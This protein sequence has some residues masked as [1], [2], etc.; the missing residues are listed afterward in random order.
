[1]YAYQNNLLSIPASILYDD[2][3]L[4]S[5]STYKVWCFR[6]KLIRTRQ[7]KGKGNCA[8]VSF[9]DI[10][11]EW[12]KNAIKAKY[13]DPKEKIIEN[14][15]EN[16]IQT[17][18]LAIKFFAAHIKPNGRHL[19]AKDQ[20]TKVNSVSILNA[21]QT[22][23]NSRSNA[24]KLFG[25]QK[26]KVWQNISEA[27]NNINTKKW[28]Y[29]LPTTSRTLQRK[30]KRYLN[31]GYEA[32]IHAG[33][34]SKNAVRITKAVGDY[35]LALYSLPSGKLTI[36][37]VNE[38]YELERQ[39]HKSW[40][41]LTNS[42]I[43]EFLYKPEN[44]RIWTLARHGK[45]AY[46]RKYKH[47]ITRDKS[48]WF[49]NA[50]WAIDGTK[51]DWIHFW[52]DASNKMGAKLKINVLFDVYS[53]KIIGSAISF[54][55]SHVE[56]FKAIK[57][58]INEAECRPYF[59]TYDNQSGHKSERMQT[60]YDSLVA[61]NKGVHYAGAAYEHGNPAEGLFRRLQQQV[62]NKFWF[63]D[64]QSVTVRRDD[65]KMNTDFISTHK[66][67]L[68]TIEELYQAWEAAVALWNSKVHPNFKA[69]KFT[70]D[71]VYQHQM[72][73]QEP[74]SMFE[75]MDKMWVE[76]KK[77]PITY[78]A[79]GID[80]WIS[81]KKY[82]YEVYD[83]NG[84]IDIEFRRTS[85]GKKFIVR[86]DPEHLDTYIQLCEKDHYGN[87]V[88]VANAEPK[89]KIQEIPVLMKDGDKEQALKDLN[90]RTLELERDQKA[91]ADLVART[92]ISVESEMQDQDLLIKFKGNLTKV[93]RSK[94][95]ATET[96]SAAS[97]L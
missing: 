97:R 58:G 11:E 29:K 57:M 93:Q 85:V 78:K 13:G 79:H 5:Y 50:Y 87:I 73:M 51:L 19:S 4:M 17:D 44:E 96:L 94:V 60:L 46:K 63:N 22:V 64:G 39:N 75:I 37:E 67:E 42:A 7:G 45:E 10:A 95:E 68:K 62:I 83:A 43:Y 12:V 6:G 36:P 86:Y 28:Q 3:E 41:P 89:R 82:Q 25:K 84:D 34:G 80:L 18:P 27:V 55:E 91:Y 23:F 69:E 21:I 54:T 35:L 9:Y 32:F 24:A 2:M 53:E 16:F 49:P 56:H 20:R 48:Q 30:Y 31:E 15:L 47:T 71:Q 70:R 72:P 52:D 61:E 59:M 26:T 77:R 40:K 76:Q 92:G 74:L 65:N 14:T 8:W 66:S 1:M 81:D 88:H 33:E 38:R 90:V